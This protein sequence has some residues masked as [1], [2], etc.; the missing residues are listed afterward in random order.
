MAT[1]FR[2]LFTVP[3]ALLTLELF[4]K[5]SNIVQ[6]QAMS[7]VIPNTGNQNKGF[8]GTKRF[9]P[10]QERTNPFLIH[11]ENKFIFLSAHHSTK[12]LSEGLTNLKP[13]SKPIYDHQA[14]LIFLFGLMNNI[15]GT[16]I[17]PAMLC[18]KT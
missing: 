10:A 14:P 13:I 8:A 6:F 3:A 4:D 17:L 2:K 5:K 18:R 16:Y 12:N 15:D 11:L 7:R 1:L 9:V